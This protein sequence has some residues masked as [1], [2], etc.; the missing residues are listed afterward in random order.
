MQP[1]KRRGKHYGVNT[2]D[3]SAMQSNYIIQGIILNYMLYLL[4]IIDCHKETIWF[5][6]FETL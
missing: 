4:Y 6:N 2:S 5:A 1:Q 3:R